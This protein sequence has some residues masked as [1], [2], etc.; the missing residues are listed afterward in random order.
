[1]V[2]DSTPDL[3]PSDV[4]PEVLPSAIRA[5]VP[6]VTPP[7]SLD[8]LLA[9]PLLPLVEASPKGPGLPPEAEQPIPRIAEA[10]ATEETVWPGIKTENGVRRR[11]CSP[12]LLVWSEAVAMILDIEE[13][14]L[15]CRALDTI[16]IGITYTTV[17][18]Y[19]APNVHKST[20]PSPIWL[21]HKCA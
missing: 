9:A 21:A 20:Y 12:I 2:P 3:L 18:I 7:P 19:G 16:V 8:P 14:A 17:V 5:T 6:G 1:V 13:D 11:A 10:S 4:S 15:S